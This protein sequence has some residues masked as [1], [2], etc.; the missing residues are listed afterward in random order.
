ML[1]APTG[2]QLLLAPQ[3]P[4][5]RNRNRPLTGRRMASRGLWP[6]GLHQDHAG[7]FGPCLLGNCGQESRGK[8]A[9]FA[10]LR[11]VMPMPPARRLNLGKPRGRAMSERPLGSTTASPARQ[12]S[13]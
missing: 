2:T 7:S 3:A 11:W 6:F 9:H 12:R 5:E 10:C 4:R 1:R 8:F 13:I